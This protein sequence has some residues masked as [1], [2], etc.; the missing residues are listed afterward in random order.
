MGG[1][2]YILWAAVFTDCGRRNAV[3]FGRRFFVGAD[4]IRPLF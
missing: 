3:R 4:I 1:I 2:C